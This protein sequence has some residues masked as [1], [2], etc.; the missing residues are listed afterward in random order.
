MA[1]PNPTTL[2]ILALLPFIVW[3][4]YARVRRMLTRQKLSRWRPWATLVAFPLLLGLLSL[5]AFVMPHPQPE[6]LLWLVA[7]LAIGVGLGVL[8]LQ[9][10]RYEVTDAGLFYTPDARLGIALSVMLVGRFVWRMGELLIS[11]P[12]PP[13]RA[14][15]FTFSPFTL[16]P[17]GMLAGYYMLYAAGLIRW[18]WRTAAAARP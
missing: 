15:E 2:T 17:I 9:R 8:G 12:V 10:T 7:G 6:R 4:L 3:R 11:G 13:E 16:V 5:S 14:N 1:A 18:K